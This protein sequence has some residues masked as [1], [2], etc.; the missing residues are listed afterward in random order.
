M[1]TQPALCTLT[2]SVQLNG[3][4]LEKATVRARLTTNPSTVDGIFLSTAWASVKTDISGTAEL[5]LIQQGEF[6]QGDGTYTIEA[7]FKGKKMWSVTAQ[8]PNESTAN[9]ED[10]I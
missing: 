10:L 9:L 3:S 5:D 4:P 1:P 2:A 6:T 8:M 7:Y